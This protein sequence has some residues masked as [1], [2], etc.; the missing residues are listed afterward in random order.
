M[1]QPKR[2]YVRVIYDDGSFAT[3]EKNGKTEWCKRTAW[4]IANHMWDTHNLMA[5]VIPA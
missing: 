3:V 1:K 5:Y 2:F 4:K